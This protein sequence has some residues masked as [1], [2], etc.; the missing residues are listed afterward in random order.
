MTLFKLVAFFSGNSFQEV[1]MQIDD[2]ETKPL[3]F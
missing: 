1:L 3:K 2:K